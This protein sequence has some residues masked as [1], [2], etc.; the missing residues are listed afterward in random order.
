MM[1]S[2]YNFFLGKPV[3]RGVLPA[4]IAVPILVAVLLPGGPAHAQKSPAVPPGPG[5]AA[6]AKPAKIIKFTLVF[7]RPG[8]YL[9]YPIRNG[10]KGAGIDLEPGQNSLPIEVTADI[11]GIEILDEINGLVATRSIAKIKNNSTVRIGADAFDQL[12]AVII[13]LKSKNGLPAARGVVR[14]ATAKGEPL[15]YGLNANDNGS[16][17]FE[18][19]ALGKAQASG[20]ATSGDDVVKQTVI[21]APQVGGKPQVIAL[22]LP[23]DVPTIAPP[24]PAAPGAA[25]GGGTPTIIVNTGEG[26]QESRND[27]ASG[28]VGL[29]VL[30][31][32]AFWGLRYLKQRG[33]TAQEAVAEGLQRL[34]VD[35]PN[36]GLPGSP[37]AGLRSSGPGVVQAPL[38]SLAE[39]PE[40]S[41]ATGR[42]APEPEK[43][44]VGPRLIGLAG[45]YAGRTI[46]L[47][48]DT[49]SQ[50]TIGRDP[51]TTIALGSDNSVSRRHA[52]IV[53][54]GP[55]W[56]LMDEASQN[57][58]H[59]NGRRIEDRTAL[60]T[61]D[62]IQIGKARFRFEA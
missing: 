47:Q 43:T 59:V 3:R 38:P 19:I 25:T 14:L 55:G 46:A 49:E 31:A 35:S 48:S 1:S 33:M 52:V 20:Y 51:A 23:V 40:A 21:I 37:H 45:E 44:F 18:N 62:V 11:D 36:A 22:T 34:G 15:Q 13:E 27:W 32:A 12:Q 61:G 28:V 41:I 53:P 29:A 56:D 26:K 39:L 54:N 2:R 5:G 42:V 6:T 17:R 50:L 58:T 57:G 8:S 60:T 10:R 9:C 24:S 16:V 4:R 7:S 30:G